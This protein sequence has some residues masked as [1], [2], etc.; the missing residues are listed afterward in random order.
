MIGLLAILVS[1]GLLLVFNSS[2][3]SLLSWIILL[4][5]HSCFAVVLILLLL[6]SS[7]KKKERKAVSMKEH[8]D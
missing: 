3:L 8:S 2:V 5:A 7:K 6:L 4:F 1:F